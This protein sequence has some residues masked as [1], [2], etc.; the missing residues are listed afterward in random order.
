MSIPSRLRMLR[1][2]L[3]QP[4]VFSSGADGDN[5]EPVML[6]STKLSLSTWFPRGHRKLI[7][8]SSSPANLPTTAHTNAWQHRW[9]SEHDQHLYTRRAGRARLRQLPIHPLREED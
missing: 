9:H 4:D 6:D 3:V 1:R 7:S 2:D 8:P 5:R